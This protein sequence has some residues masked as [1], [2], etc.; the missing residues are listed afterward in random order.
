MLE[1]YN[2]TFLLE[3]IHPLCFV[4][5]NLFLLTQSKVLRSEHIIWSSVQIFDVTDRRFNHLSYIFFNK[6]SKI[7]NKT[8]LHDKLNTIFGLIL[9]TQNALNKIFPWIYKQCEKQKYILLNRFKY[10]IYVVGK[11]RAQGEDLWY[12]SRIMVSN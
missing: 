7:I 6:H 8:E 4:S 11:K 1:E 5:Q 3:K 12:D 2:S 9:Y 10:Q